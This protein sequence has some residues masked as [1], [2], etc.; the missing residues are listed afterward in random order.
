M[1]DRRAKNVQSSDKSKTGRK[2]GS[3]P[4]AA[5]RLSGRRLWLYRFLASILVPACFFGLLE[6]VL[7]LAGFG[8][9]TTFLLPTRMGGQKVFVQNNQFGWRFFGRE[10]ARWPYPF[11]ISQ[12]K[13]TN[14]VRIFVFGESAARGEPQPE[15]GLPR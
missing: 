12:S 13:A 8:Y 7:W 4:A 10:M 6:L 15:F 1:A 14:T 2:D 5:P 3:A 9:S 11:S